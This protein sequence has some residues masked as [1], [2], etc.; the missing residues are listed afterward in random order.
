MIAKS[1]ECRISCNIFSDDQTF[2]KLVDKKKFNT[3]DD[4][5]I[6]VT[7]YVIK[8]PIY[9]ATTTLAIF[10]VYKGSLT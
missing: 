4:D 6:P 8:A 2:Y 5:I 10:P 1:G 9:P 7:V 3:I